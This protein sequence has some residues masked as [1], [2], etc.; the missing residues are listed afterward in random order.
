MTSHVMLRDR[1]A[2][3]R[4]PVPST[5]MAH[6]TL[7]ESILTPF[8]TTVVLNIA[9]ITGSTENFAEMSRESSVP[10]DGGSRTI[11]QTA[12]APGN[13]NQ[14]NEA[15]PVVGVLKLRGDRPARRQKVVFS[16]ET[17]D[18]EGMGKKKS[19]SKSE[20]H[21]VFRWVYQVAADTLQ[22]V[23]SITS[24]ERTTNHQTNHQV[25]RATVDTIMIDTM[26]RNKLQHVKL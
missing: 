24:R 12:S 15:G 8:C 18:N 17:V 21:T 20:L 25:T 3:C 13:G 22:Y 26:L 10:A 2:E 14:N 23:A 16:E 5:G 6:S 11:T 9:P 19:K 7:L 1:P 4:V